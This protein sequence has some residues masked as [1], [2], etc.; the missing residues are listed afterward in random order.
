M[1][2]RM[3]GIGSLAMLGLAGCAP[4]QGAQNRP[5]EFRVI[6]SLRIDDGLIN[7]LVEG[8]GPEAE[9]GIENF[10]ECAAISK[11]HE[12]GFG[13]ARRI[14]THVSKTG[15]N[16][17]ADAVYS[18]SKSLPDGLRTIDAEVAAQNCAEAGIQLG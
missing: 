9:T 10:A 7:I 11:A 12:Q 17:R 15:G 4:S 18:V 2:A 1:M 6:D 16:W 3:V 13:F 14:R 5:T 8:H